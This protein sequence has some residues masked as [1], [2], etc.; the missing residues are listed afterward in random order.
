LDLAAE[1]PAVLPCFGWDPVSV[2]DRPRDWLHKLQLVMQTGRAA[3]G[4]VGV[5]RSQ[6]RC[7]LAEQL[8][9]L[10]AQ[11]DLAGQCHCPVVL[12]CDRD[13]VLVLKI[14]EGLAKHPL[15]V[16]WYGFT[17][18]VR[19][20]EPLVRLGV[21]FAYAGDLLSHKNARTKRVCKAVPLDR[22]LLATNAPGAL[23]P[24]PYAPYQRL[25][26]DHHRVNEPA[27]LPH[28][29]DGVAHWLGQDPD[30][31]A[32]ILTHNALCL[33]GSLIPGDL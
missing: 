5:D 16:L 25:D 29:I 28:I 21:Y 20:I 2:A 30:Q 33:F 24:A 9:V 23:P 3:V 13:A 18:P 7:S 31:L 15:G 1:A 32:Q 27:N 10:S 22:L 14:L 12:R 8:E 11:L 19:L 26:A 6:R 4:M 17:G